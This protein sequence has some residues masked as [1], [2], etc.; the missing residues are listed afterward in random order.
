MKGGTLKTEY[1]I[2][3]FSL[4]LILPFISWLIGGLLFIPFGLLIAYIIDF[5]FPKW[6]YDLSWQDIDRALNN[7]YKFGC[8]PCELCFLVGSRRI[9]I[10]RD[11]QIKYRKNIKIIR[12]S[13]R[14]PV[15]E[16]EDIFDENFDNLVELF[17]GRGFFSSNR[18]SYSYGIFPMEGGEGCKNILKYLFEKSVGGLRPDI[19]AES[20]VNAKKNIWI[21]HDNREG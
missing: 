5:F 3:L 2:L 9:F 16:W 15:S 18:R 11:E 19:Y 17:G 12:M 4:Y 6:Q 13:V 7:I 14:I 8:S 1:S 21:E 20:V 10:Y